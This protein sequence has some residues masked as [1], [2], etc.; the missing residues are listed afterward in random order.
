MRHSTHVFTHRVEDSQGM[1]NKTTVGALLVGLV[2]AAA[3]PA[4]AHPSGSSARALTLATF[5]VENPSGCNEVT[6]ARCSATV[7]AGTASDPVMRESM[8]IVDPLSPVG[9]RGD[10]SD[11][12]IAQQVAEDTIPKSV[13]RVTYEWSFVVD[14][15]VASVV[16]GQTGKG[17]FA[18][19]LTVEPHLDDCPSFLYTPMQ[20]FETREGVAAGTSFRFRV[21]YGPCAGMN[22]IP[23]GTHATFTA[24]LRLVGW[25]HPDDT[26]AWDGGME[27]RGAV[28]T[29]SVSAS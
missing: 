13:S 18:M 16:S 5:A 15:A 17:E 21:T 19:D 27:L 3:P 9:I 22:R 10:V 24:R 6:L 1:K 28:R 11:Y 14:E 23:A 12:V 4:S 8:S 2:L 26:G 20:V 7:T 29:V 25:M